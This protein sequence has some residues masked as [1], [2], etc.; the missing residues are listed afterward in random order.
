MATG[1]ENY[2]KSEQLLNT[3]NVVGNPTPAQILQVQ[4]A[5]V[6]AT[7]ALAAATALALTGV[8]EADLGKWAALVCE[9]DSPDTEVAATP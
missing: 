3:M 5:Q 2:R 6:R 9:P 4:I 1:P 7:L 8:G